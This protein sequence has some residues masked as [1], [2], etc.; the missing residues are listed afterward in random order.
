MDSGLT[1]WMERYIAAWDSND[2]AAI[3]GLFSDE[4]DYRSYPWAVPVH[5]PEEIVD[6][7][8]SDADQPGDHRFSWREIGVDGDRHFVQAHTAYADGRTYENLWI[9]D[10][11]ADGRAR[12]FTEWYM[13]RRPEA[14]PEE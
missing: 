13:R 9:V 8:L 1:G 12:E 10:L 5:G 11:D 2:P 4:A 6:R 7:W 3:A 14:I